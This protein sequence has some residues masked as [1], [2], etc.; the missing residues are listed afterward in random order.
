MG[1]TGDHSGDMA[2]DPT[3]SL[4]YSFFIL[5]GEEDEMKALETLS[6]LLSSGL[7]CGQIT[8]HL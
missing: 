2:R 4:L 1:G 5:G 8:D 3:Q 6:P 7:C